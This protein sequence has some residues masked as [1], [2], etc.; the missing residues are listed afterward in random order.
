MS[1]HA[2]VHFH[3]QESKYCKIGKL[4]GG[5]NGLVSALG[6]SAMFAYLEGIGDIKLWK[7]SVI[8]VFNL[9][10]KLYH[11]FRS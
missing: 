9:E 5:K 10:T 4:I 8:L 2:V 6:W 7:Q 11:K 1:N 3:T